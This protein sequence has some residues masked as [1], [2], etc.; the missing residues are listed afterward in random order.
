MPMPSWEKSPQELVELFE[1]VMPGP[2]AVARKMFGYPAGFVNGNMF[3]GLFQTRFVVRLPEDQRR[4]LLTV[5]GAEIFEPMEGRAMKEYVS[6]PGSMGPD[7]LEPWV[8]KAL[9]YAGAMPTKVPKPRTPK[10]KAAPKA[11]K[12]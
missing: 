8:A 1:Q 11:K 12:Q 10:A 9:A 6:L 4:E 7:A 3:I 2:P 5:E